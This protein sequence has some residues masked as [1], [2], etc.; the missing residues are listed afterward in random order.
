MSTQ[1]SGI[2]A[3]VADMDRGVAFYRDVIGLPLKF[4]SRME[5]VCYRGIHVRSAFYI[6][7]KRCWQD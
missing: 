4:H 5:Q 2:I 7:Q 1:L 6:G 3:F